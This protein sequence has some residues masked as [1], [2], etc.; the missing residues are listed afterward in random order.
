MSK[1]LPKIPVKPEMEV[2][3]T[4]EEQVVFKQPEEKEVENI[5]VETKEIKI[6]KEAS[7]KQK[8]HLER[9]RAK[10]LA[11][12]QAK[13]SLKKSAQAIVAPIIQQELPSA[14]AQPYQELPTTP[15]QQEL[16]PQQVH[17]DMSH[18]ESVVRS[19]MTNVLNEERAK[20]SARQ[21]ARQEVL[22][23]KQGELDAKNKE[24]ENKKAR[25]ALLRGRN[26]RNFYY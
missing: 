23:K 25:D 21:E 3:D 6:K 22:Q 5:I 10:S 11:T 17:F 9:I 19:T 13:A 26:R 2:K 1:L 12:R 4:P 16:P 20:V 15:I 24:I 7:A 18:I 14:P 8:A